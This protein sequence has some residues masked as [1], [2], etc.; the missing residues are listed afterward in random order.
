LLAFTFDI[1]CIIMLSTS[2]KNNAKIS[3]L[4]VLFCFVFL[5]LDLCGHYYEIPLESVLKH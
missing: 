2:W 4:F 1:A 5:T 3:V